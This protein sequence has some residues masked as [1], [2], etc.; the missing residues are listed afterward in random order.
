V[1]P[2]LDLD[3]D[4]V[5]RIVEVALFD[6]ERSWARD[7]TLLRVADPAQAT[8]RIIVAA[9]DTVD[10]ICA[11]VG[12]NTAGIFSCWTGRIAALN[13]MRWASGAT[14][15]DDLETYR[16]Y[17]VNHEVGHAFGYGHV[18]CPGDGEPAPVMMQQSKGLGRC[19][20]NG[21]PHP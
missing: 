4:E 2:T 5:V 6:T 19:V 3:L 8:I 9:P 21:W 13:S 1:E 16:T 20:A 17:L 15:F 10:A 14:G 18:G 12:L 7:R 11:T